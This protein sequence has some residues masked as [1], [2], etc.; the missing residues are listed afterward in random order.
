[1]ND[2]RI[3]LTALA[4]VAFQTAFGQKEI[5]EHPR[6]DQLSA[7]H[8]TLAILPF[9]TYLSLEDVGRQQRDK[10][11][12]REGYAVQQALELYFS[13]KNKRRKSEVE[14]QNT[15]DTNA[16]LKQNS[17]DY[18]NI[19]LYTTQQLCEFLRVDGIISGH[20]N[21]NIL[22]SEGI[23][24]EFNLLQWFGVSSNFGRIGLKIS[25]GQSGKLL[26]KYEK[27]I[28]R[29]TGKDT[30]ELIDKMMKQASRRF[31]YEKEAR[32]KDR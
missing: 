2:S 6:F 26:W 11:A 9:R 15:V 19:D 30:R 22:L 13:R 29:K 14:F 1:M 25:D 4:F 24:E 21:V 3:W 12:E 20:L 32:P 5:Y 18:S 23:P 8:K 7:H 16:L 27:E 31:P 17:I 10:L 28:D